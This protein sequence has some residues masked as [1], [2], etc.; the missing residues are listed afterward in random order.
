MPTSND[1][2]V[3][4]EGFSKMT[5]M[6]RPASGPLRLHPVLVAAGLQGVGEV[7][8]LGLLGG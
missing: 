1:M 7:E 8:H 6:L 2:R 3:R 4:V 5:A